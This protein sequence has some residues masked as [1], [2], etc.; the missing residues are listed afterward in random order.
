LN[1]RY[2]DLIA[3]PEKIIIQI[4]DLLKSER[5]THVFQ[6]IEDSTKRDRGESFSTY[7]KY[8]L[9]EQW[10][11]NLNSETIAIVNSNLDRDLIEAFGY[12]LLS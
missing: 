9:E 1:L 6:N 11:K 7:K 12:K 2:E 3:D 10:K 8:Y 5:K 4:A